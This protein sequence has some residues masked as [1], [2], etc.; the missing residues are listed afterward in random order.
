[1]KMR[2]GIVLTA[3]VVL[4]MFS[5]AVAADYDISGKWL[6]EGGGFAEKGVLR[7]E[8]TDEGFLDIRTK[9]EDGTRYVLGYSVALWLNASRLGINAWE[10]SKNVDLELPIPIPSLNPT[11]NDPF[12]LPPVTVDR[13]TYKVTFTSISSGTVDIY[14]SLDVD[15]I[16]DVEID[17]ASAICKEGTEKPDIPDMTSGCNSGII[18][19]ALVLGVFWVCRKRGR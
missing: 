17:S 19:A 7:V 5:K 9:V 8:L 2:K 15:V 12:K 10:Y 4:F 3:V 18:G 6:L 16:G 14:G 1:M 11:V 13:L